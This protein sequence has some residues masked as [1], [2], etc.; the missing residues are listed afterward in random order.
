MRQNAERMAKLVMDD[1]T[2]TGGH[3]RRGE[4]ESYA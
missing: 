2:E 1:A 4:A 3:L